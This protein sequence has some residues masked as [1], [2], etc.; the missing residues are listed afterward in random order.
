MKYAWEGNKFEIDFEDN[1]APTAVEA[2]QF[3]KNV[4]DQMLKLGI[5]TKLRNYTAGKDTAEARKAIA[6]GLEQLLAGN[7][8]VDREKIELTTDEQNQVIGSFIVAAKRARG[9]T[10][11]EDAILSAWNGLPGDK[12]DAVLK[13]N[14][15]GIKRALAERLKAKKGKGVE[16]GF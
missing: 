16:V 14:A 7:W 15:K 4:L 13:A 1:G 11:A 10:R 9:D 6:T 2:S 8:G 12:K 5:R 3:P